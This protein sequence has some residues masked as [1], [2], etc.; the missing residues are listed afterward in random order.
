MFLTVFHSF[1]TCYA[2]EQIALYKRATVSDLLPSLFK[3]TR[4]IGIRSLKRAIYYCILSL[5]KNKIRS[6]NQRANSQPWF[7]QDLSNIEKE[8][9]WKGIFSQGL[10]SLDYYFVYL[11]GWS[12]SR[13]QIQ[14]PV[15][16]SSTLKKRSVLF[17]F[18]RLVIFAF[19]NSSYS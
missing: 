16:C 2:Q 8:N 14:A 18:W 19:A 5:K 17:F 6:K 3:K 15:P 13:H 4:E 12:R 7:S 1:S 9:N 11:S 10:L